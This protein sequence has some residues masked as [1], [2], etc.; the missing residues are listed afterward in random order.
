MLQFCEHT[1]NTLHALNQDDLRMQPILYFPLHTFSDS[2]RWHKAHLHS[3]CLLRVPQLACII[4]A[5]GVHRP[6]TW[7]QPLSGSAPLEADHI[8][9]NRL[10]RSAI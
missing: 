1:S 7:R 3:G 2:L 5:E 8:Q 10:L 9:H 4:Q 6:V